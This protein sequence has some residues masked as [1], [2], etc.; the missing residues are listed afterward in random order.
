MLRTAARRD[1]GEPAVGGQRPAETPRRRQLGTGTAAG[2]PVDARAFTFHSEP[3]A[4]G[5]GDAPLRAPG[6]GT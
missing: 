4:K 3:A 6:T 1:L 2:S 5:R